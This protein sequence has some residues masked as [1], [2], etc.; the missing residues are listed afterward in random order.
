MINKRMLPGVGWMAVVFQA[1]QAPAQVSVNGVNYVNMYKALAME[2]E[3]RS[4]V[5]A[6]IKIGR[7]H[8]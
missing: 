4:G 8:V 7:A 6:S 5:P 3:Q 2:E 1:L